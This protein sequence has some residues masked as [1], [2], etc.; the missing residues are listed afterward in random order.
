MN[1]LSTHEQPPEKA[2][3]RKRKLS[4]RLY[5]QIEESIN[6]RNPKLEGKPCLVNYLG[7]DKK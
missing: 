2:A 4:A 5:V 3:Q 7:A 6:M 1:Q